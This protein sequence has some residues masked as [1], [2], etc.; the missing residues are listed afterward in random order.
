MCLKPP[1]YSHSNVFVPWCSLISFPKKTSNHKK[2]TVQ[3]WRSTFT[4]TPRVKNRAPAPLNISSTSSGL[5]RSPTMLTERHHETRAWHRLRFTN[6]TWPLRAQ[7]SQACT[8]SRGCA[9]VLHLTEVDIRHQPRNGCRPQQTRHQRTH[10][11][12]HDICT[13]SAR[14]L[15]DMHV[16]CGY[17]AIH[18]VGVLRRLRL[19]SGSTSAKLQ[20]RPLAKVA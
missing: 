11:C 17:G 19:H 20:Q 8:G 18:Y 6:I 16:S 1:P 7:I 14:H 9:L 10:I 12:L 3:I 2:T 15:R 4:C 13:T 5:G